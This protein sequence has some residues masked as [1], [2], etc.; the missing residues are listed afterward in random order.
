MTLTRS[1]TLLKL[2]KNT[3]AAICSLQMLMCHP[4]LGRKI[5]ALAGFLQFSVFFAAACVCNF[6]GKFQRQISTA[7]LD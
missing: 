7:N 3:I 6:N 5:A 4:E 2:S 1:W